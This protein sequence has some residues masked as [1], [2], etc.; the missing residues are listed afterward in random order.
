MMTEMHEYKKRPYLKVF[1]WL[2]VLT[3]VEVGVAS[4]EFD[5]ALLIIVLAALA[6]VKVSLV[7]LYYMHLRYDNRILML[8][9]GFPF[10]LAAVMTLIILADRTLVG[11]FIGG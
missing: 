2:A 3:A 9:G 6:M 1:V 10:L 4:L 8:I 5:K 11:G 7:A